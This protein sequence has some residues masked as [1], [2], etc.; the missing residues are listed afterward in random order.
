MLRCTVSLTTLFLVTSA[1]ADSSAIP[2]DS[3]PEQIAAFQGADNN[4][5]GA[6]TPPEFTAFIE[7]M[8]DHGAE[9]AQFIRTFGAY[10]VA[11][12]QVDSDG[13]GYARPFEIYNASTA[14]EAEGASSAIPDLK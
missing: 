8:A 13:D 1:M 14:F 2:P 9:T 4:G 10:S 5:D 3:T 12:S 6:L 11:F 7:T